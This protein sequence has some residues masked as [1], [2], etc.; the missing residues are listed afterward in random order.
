MG[1]ALPIIAHSP[2]SPSKAS[3]A[4][5]CPLAFKYRYIDKIPSET[6]GSAAKVGVTV[7]L[8]QELLLKGSPPRDA[9]ERAITENEQELTE[10]EKETVRTFIQNIISFQD[11]LELFKR[12]S[13]VS[14]MLLEKKWAI[15]VHFNA[16]SYY[17]LN[18]A[19]VRGIVDL[20]LFL[21]CGYVI[22]IDH[23]S[24]R[25]R[26]A[27]YYR[28]QLDFYAIMALAHFPDAKGVQ[29]ALNYLAADKVIWNE[30]IRSD[31]IRKTLHPWLLQYLSTKAKHVEEAKPVIGTHCN[32]CDY[33]KLCPA[34]GSDAERTADNH[35]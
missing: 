24:G 35:Q 10:P 25:V 30:P 5:Q 26:P 28:T 13:G 12:K 17:A 6:R 8:A 19:I 16:C 9:I 31:Y 1:A 33:K 3:L 7:H 15:D 2:W 27:A 18:E 20:S 4:G 21:D 11:K 32:W 34:W 23:K 22:I 29:C 14:Q